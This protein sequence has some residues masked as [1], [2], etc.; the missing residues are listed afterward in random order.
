MTHEEI[1]EDY[2]DD[3]MHDAESFL[4]DYSNKEWFRARIK[5][6]LTTYRAQVLGRKKMELEEEFERGGWSENQ[7][8][9]LRDL[10]D[11]PTN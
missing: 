3:I 5:S 8:E 10:F 2:L 6:A 9:T 4:A 1:V 7:M 11:D